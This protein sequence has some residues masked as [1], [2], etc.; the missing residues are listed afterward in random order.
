MRTKILFSVSAL[1]FT[2]AGCG[3]QD[4]AKI[5]ESEPKV[6]AATGREGGE[7][8]TN[9]DNKYA[10]VREVQAARKYDTVGE[11]VPVEEISIST[12][13]GGTVVKMHVDVG[14]VIRDGSMIA[15][16][17]KE[18][19]KLQ[20]DNAKA[21][22][23][24]ASASLENAKSEYNRK[25]QLFEEEAIPES[26]FE[27]VKTQLELAEARHKSAEVAVRMADKALRD[28][29]VKAAIKGA[30]LGS[31]TQNVKGLVSERKV[32]AGEFVGPGVVLVKIIIVQPIKMEFSVPERFAAAISEGSPV[33][34]RLRAYPEKR[35]EG[36]V[37]RIN[38]TADTATRTLQLEAE[39]LNEEG[40][41][42]P[43]FFTECET[44]LASSETYYIVPNKAIHISDGRTEVLVLRNDDEEPEAVMVT[45]VE[46]MGSNSKIIGP[47]EGGQ[48][49]RLR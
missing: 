44:E 1:V 28:T 11:F 5:L 21:Q 34:A 35:F 38:P 45:L 42:K 12:K 29:E 17:D 19:Y 14:D 4:G 26:T 8:E 43:G 6:E 30:V 15:E 10:I 20:V 49:V 27:L 32:S 2:L 37:T 36:K 18:D 3:S 23:E 9:A 48:R 41:L 31:E 22:Q 40:I 16:I 33:V 46:R 13:V 24:V 7:E 47:L 25:K 39:F